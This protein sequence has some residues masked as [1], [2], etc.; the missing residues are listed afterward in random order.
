MSTVI[1]L[2]KPPSKVEKWIKDN[3]APKLDEPL[4][5]TAMDAG[6]TI[7]FNKVGNLVDRANIVTSTDG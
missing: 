1:F 6:A 4:C 3:Y 7:T 5:F 2:G